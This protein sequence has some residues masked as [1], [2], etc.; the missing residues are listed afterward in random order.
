ML[1]AST[2]VCSVLG[3]LWL[4]TLPDQAPVPF[5]R[6]PF[7]PTAQESQKPYNGLQ[8]N[9]CLVVTGWGDRRVG[10]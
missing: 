2:I 1:A 3:C 6:E 4:R 10:Q 7:A 8:V 9:S 5:P